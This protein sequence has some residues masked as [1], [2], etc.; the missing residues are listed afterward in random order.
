MMLWTT[1]VFRPGG[2]R[3]ARLSTNI[4]LPR[5]GS[6]SGLL[7]AVLGCGVGVLLGLAVSAVAPVNLATAVMCG[8]M[9][10]GAAGVA[11]VVARPWAGEH[12]GRVAAVRLQ[13][14]LGARRSTCPGSGRLP[15]V[16]DRTGVASCRECG[17][18]CADS[19]SKVAAEH[20][21]R[22]RLYSG[23]KP[24]PDAYYGAVDVVWGS[25][26]VRGGGR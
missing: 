4:V 3:V 15:H 23:M 25:V 14:T 22:R 18:V 9:F 12:T 16:D 2:A 17:V 8:A 13:A 20:E 24:V 10:G 5:S 26:P 21:W 19:E 6:V 7:G 11:L 1:K